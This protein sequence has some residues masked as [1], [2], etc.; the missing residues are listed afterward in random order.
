MSR[1]CAASCAGTDAGALAAGGI[2]TGAK[3][4]EAALTPLERRC[5]AAAS[6]SY[7]CNL[8]GGHMCAWVGHGGSTKCV[9]A[10][11]AKKQHWVNQCPPVKRQMLGRDPSIA[12]YKHKPYK[13]TAPKPT[14]PTSTAEA[15]NPTP[16][17]DATTPTPSIQPEAKMP[18]PKLIPTPKQHVP[19]Q[20]V[21]QEPHSLPASV[22]VCVCMCVCVC[23]CVCVRTPD[24]VSGCC[25]DEGEGESQT[26][27]EKPKE[28]TAKR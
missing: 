24:G 5:Q 16:Q 13:P 18:K 2:I 19:P 8:D 26:A 7:C 1:L 27:P 12:K 3:T 17:P 10:E 21:R 4:S 23:V 9:T 11:A 25:P 20:V 6:S 14:A 22:C 28:P 15:A